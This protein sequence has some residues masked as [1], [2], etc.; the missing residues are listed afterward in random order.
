MLLYPT[1]HARRAAALGEEVPAIERLCR[2]VDGVISV[3]EHIAYRMG[4]A[5]H[6]SNGT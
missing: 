2:S 6:P 4:D 5:R 3:S 1:C